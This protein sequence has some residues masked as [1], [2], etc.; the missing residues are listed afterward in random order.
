[1]KRLTSRKKFKAKLLASK[2]WLKANRTTPAPELMK[3][4]VAKMRGYIAYYGVSDN[5]RGISRYVHEVGKLLFKWLNRRGKRGS[6]T[7]RKFRKF[8]KS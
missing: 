1:M 6:L 3:T 5:S 2:E 7:L 4:V 8:L